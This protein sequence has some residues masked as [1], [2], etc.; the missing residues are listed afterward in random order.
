MAC[1][2]KISLWSLYDWSESVNIR[3]VAEYKKI[4]DDLNNEYASGEE[5][6]FLYRGHGN[7]NQYELLRM[8]RLLRIC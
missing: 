7:H 3:S 5:N 2:K 1:G 6:R 4:I 8:S